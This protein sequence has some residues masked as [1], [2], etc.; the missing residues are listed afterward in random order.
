MT[1]QTKAAHLLGKVGEELGEAAQAV[2]K[3]TCY[4]LYD[5]YEDRLPNFK[6]FQFEIHDIIGAYEMYCHEVGLDPAIDRGLVEAKKLRVIHYMKYA[7]EKGHLEPID[8]I[9]RID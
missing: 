7:R 4:G 2:G 3:I 1:K 9:D 5:Q 6:A 8:G